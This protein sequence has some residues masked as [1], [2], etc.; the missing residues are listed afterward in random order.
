MLNVMVHIFSRTASVKNV[1]LDN[2][3][4]ALVDLILGKIAQV[5]E[6][7]GY[8]IYSLDC[9][10]GCSV[11]SSG[12]GKYC[13]NCFADFYLDEYTCLQCPVGYSSPAGATSASLCYSR[14]YVVFFYLTFSRRVL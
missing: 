3:S 5:E 14:F 13:S 2:F 12:D 7:K 9:P 4:R 10:E 8:L 11:C 1:P 6:I